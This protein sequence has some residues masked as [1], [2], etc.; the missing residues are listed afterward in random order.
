MIGETYSSIDPENNP[1]F[2]KEKIKGKSAAVKK[3]LGDDSDLK[4][5]GIQA[6][7]GLVKEYF[8][9][10]HEEEMQRKRNI[11]DSLAMQSEAQSLMASQQGGNFRSLMA[12]YGRLV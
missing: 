8:A 5:A 10:K 1:V 7:A 2:E 11:Q 4:S 6:G 3:E 12:H 9:Q